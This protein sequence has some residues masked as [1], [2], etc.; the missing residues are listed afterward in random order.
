MQCA[1]PARLIFVRPMRLS[2]VTNAKKRTEELAF[3]ASLQSHVADLAGWGHAAEHGD[4]IPPMRST[5]KH[6]EAAPQ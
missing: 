2:F 1:S 5:V 3:V 4:D 6:S